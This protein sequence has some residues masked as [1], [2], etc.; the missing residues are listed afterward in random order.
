MDK[1][2]KKMASFVK[3]R[4]IT[5]A[6]ISENTGIS[7]GVLYPSFSGSRSLRANEFLK[8]CNYLEIDPKLFSDEQPK[9]G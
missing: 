8:I 7:T 4:G 6:A 1:A 3:K 2:T 9:V 5:I